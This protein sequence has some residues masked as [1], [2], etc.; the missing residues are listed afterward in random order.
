M[1]VCNQLFLGQVNDATLREKTVSELCL[2]LMSQQSP[3]QSWKVVD[4]FAQKLR[5]DIYKSCTYESFIYSW[6]WISPWLVS[7]LKSG[8]TSPRFTMTASLSFY[9]GTSDVSNKAMCCLHFDQW[10]LANFRSFDWT[11]KNM[12]MSR[13]FRLAPSQPHRSYKSS[14]QTVRRKKM[15]KGLYNGS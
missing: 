10:W 12:T 3:R 14:N 4:K 8:K 15:F 7:T 9:H 2:S 1:L 6:N 5:T 11:T 13:D